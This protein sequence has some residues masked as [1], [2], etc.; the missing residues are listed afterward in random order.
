MQKNPI[1]GTAAECLAHYAANLP[2]DRRQMLETRRQMQE[3]TGASDKAALC[4]LKSRSYPIGHQLL[5]V[6]YFLESLGYNVLELN[7]LEPAVRRVGRLIAY[8]LISIDETVELCG[9]GSRSTLYHA[10]HGTRNVSGRKKVIMSGIYQRLAKSLPDTPTVTHLRQTSQVAAGNGQLNKE[11]IMR[12]L[13][14]L[15]EAA[16][17]LTSLL[18]SDQFSSEHRRRFRRLLRDQGVFRLSDNLNSL[19]SEH[20]RQQIHTD[21]TEKR[22]G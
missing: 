10:L 22:G 4:W 16:I 6:K 17:P 2:L 21:K 1:A 14:Q 7:Q 20:A 13:A 8:K 11:L 18:L 3:F 12:S 5:S 19:C 9:Y 15:L